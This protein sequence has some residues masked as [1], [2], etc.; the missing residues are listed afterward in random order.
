MWAYFKG[1]NFCGKKFSQILRMVFQSAKIN[2]SRNKKNSLICKKKKKKKKNSSDSQKIQKIFLKSQILWKINNSE[3]ENFITRIVHL[4]RK[5]RKVINKIESITIFLNGTGTDIMCVRRFLS[6]NFGEHGTNV[7]RFDAL[8]IVL[9]RFLFLC[10]TGFFGRFCNI[11]KRSHELWC[12]RLALQ[13]CYL[14]FV[15]IQ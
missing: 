13:I 2:P 8:C 15:S 5:I 12:L 4:F 10:G 14:F 3:A 9:C 6:C 7:T 1:R 11:K